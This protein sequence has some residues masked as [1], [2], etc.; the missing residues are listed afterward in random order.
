MFDPMSDSFTS[1][2]SRFEALLTTLESGYVT[3]SDK[4]CPRLFADELGR[5]RL[6]YVYLRF[7]KPAIMPLWTS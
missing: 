2:L 6:W 7:L 3:K 1:A 4:I 5:L